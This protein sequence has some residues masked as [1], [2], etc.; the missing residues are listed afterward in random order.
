MIPLS[1][2][3]MFMMHLSSYFASGSLVIVME[4][5]HTFLTSHNKNES[6]NFS[7]PFVIDN[8]TMDSKLG[9][10]EIDMRF[11]IPNYDSIT[12][13]PNYYSVSTDLV[14]DNIVETTP[15]SNKI[16]ITFMTDEILVVPKVDYQPHGYYHIQALLIEEG[17][18]KMYIRLECGSVD[19]MTITRDKLMSAKLNHAKFQVIQ[20]LQ[21]GSC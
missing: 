5:F 12:N 14:I 7:I 8:C 1:S 2:L 17:H 18:Y 13:M 4:N 16:D 3:F 9:E 11:H 15:L 20:N 21:I 19:Y 6:N 10:F